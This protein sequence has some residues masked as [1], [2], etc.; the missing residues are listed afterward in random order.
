M[1][2]SP[3]DLAGRSLIDFGQL[4]EAWN[5]AHDDGPANLSDAEASDLADWL[6]E[7]ETAGRA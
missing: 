3:G 5:A 7:V 6:D 4:V 1:G 2:M